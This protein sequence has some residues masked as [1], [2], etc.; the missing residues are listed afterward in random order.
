VASRF[1][2]SASKLDRFDVE[3]HLNVDEHELITAELAVTRF[4]GGKAAEVQRQKLQVNV[5]NALGRDIF[6]QAE[7]RQD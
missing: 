5:A 6:G 7:T 1:P 4:L 2:W 3:V